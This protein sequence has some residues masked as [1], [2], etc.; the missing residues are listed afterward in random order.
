MSRSRK[1][2]F[3]LNNPTEEEKKAVQEIKCEFIVVGLEH[4]EV[5]AEEE[6]KGG[7]GYTPHLQG[8]I[9]FETLKSLAQLKALIPR[10]HLEVAKGTFAQNYAYCS[11]EDIFFENGILPMD[12]DKKG[13]ASAKKWTDA[14]EKAK[15]GAIDEIDASMQVRFYRTWKEYRKD[16]MVCPPDL[17]TGCCGIWYHGPSGAGK[18]RTARALYPD[19]YK[20]MCNK[21]WDGY[22]DQEDVIMEDF[23]LEHHVLGHH[24]KLWAD[25]YG[26]L[27]EIK[28]TACAIRPKVIVVTSQYKIDQIWQDGETRD[29]MH[30]R[31]KEKEFTLEEEKKE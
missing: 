22:Q 3:T 14:I 8:F 10:A 11:K 25:R 7:R 1:W 28:T 15:R 30:R 5:P 31:F 12:Q 16:Y 4:V 6:N 9:Y 26:F 13:E 20:K 21:W 24:L 27:A 18:S 19:A 23:G 29:A 2:C 17:D